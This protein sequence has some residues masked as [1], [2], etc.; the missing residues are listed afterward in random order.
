MSIP[1]SKSEATTSQV[2]P[3]VALQRRWRLAFDCYNLAANALFTNA[4]SLIYLVAHGY[5][6]LAIGLFEL[7]YQVAKLIAEGPTGVFADLAGRRR[8]L[9]VSRLLLASATALYL[10]PS[11]PLLILS[12]MLSGTGQAFQGGA[13]EAVLWTMAT[14]ATGEKEATT[15]ERYSGLVSRMY[16]VGSIAEAAAV[17]LGGTLGRV[18]ATLP[19]ICQAGASLLAIP[20]LLLLPERRVPAEERP[21]PLAHFGAALRAAQRDPVLLG[22]L[23]LGALTASTWQTVF[24]YN[25]L[26]FS[27][28]GFTL[29]AIGVILA[30]ALGLGGGFTALAPRVMR[31]VPRR[32]LVP[33]LVSG[34]ALGLLIMSTG[35]PALGLV[36]FLLIFQ[37]A[38]SLLQPALSTY[39][40][41]RC[42][43]AQRATILSLQTGL[44]SAGS[45][46]IF[47]LFGLGLTQ[48]SYGAVF[49]GTLVALVAG[50]LLIGALMR[51][52]ASL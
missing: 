42:P 12:A 37:A 30:A 32:R 8:S 14:T 33:L 5:T 38:E 16:I 45:L 36:G 46:I 48:F 15:V 21:H 23:L 6:P 2:A 29:P 28:L 26:Y 35:Q 17:A 39:Q 51:R 3:P 43:E 49:A 41:E 52:R 47:P 10:L 4:V 7:V 50:S 11:V 1:S 24:Y 34:L 44:F 20:P 19:F 27:S 9:I 31:R 40:N 22:L 18:L 13:N 25:Q